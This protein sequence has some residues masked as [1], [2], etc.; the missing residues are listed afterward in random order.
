MIPRMWI[1]PVCNQL[2]P[3]PVKR[4]CPNGHGL[5]D[6]RIFGSCKQQSFAAS[7]FNTLFACVLIFAA[8][9]AFATLLPK[10]S[11]TSLNGATLA[12]FIVVG[13]GGFLRGRK[14]AR[15][16][17]PVV[18]LVPRANGMAAGCILA[19]A[20]FPLAAG[21]AGIARGLIR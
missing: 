15:Q 16:G 17:G 3:N 5:F 11:P 6:G 1:C 7:F 9:A 8:V 2:V 18:R 12:A 13:I 4:K 19:G 20:V 14:W 21:I 10:T